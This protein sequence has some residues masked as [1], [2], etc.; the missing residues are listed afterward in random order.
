MK[1]IYLCAIA[2]SVGSLS[3]GQ[4]AIQTAQPFK[5]KADVIKSATL[6]PQEKGVLI[7][8]DDFTTASNW[9]TTGGSPA[10]WTIGQ[11]AIGTGGFPLADLLSTSGAPFALWDSDNHGAGLQD[12][13]ITM[14]NPV[15]TLGY[16][17][18]S[19]SFENYFRPYNTTAVYVE[20]S[21]D[22]TTFP[23]QFQVHAAVP[24][25]G[26]T[27][28]PETTTV[29]ISAAA[30][31][32][33]QVWIRFRYTG[34][35][36]YGWAI[37]DVRIEESENNDLTVSN[38]YYG[39]DFVP[40]S[41]IPAAQVQPIDFAMQATNVGAVAQ[42]NTV[43][44]ADIN[45]GLSTH[46]SA[47]TTIA[48]GATDSLFTTTQFTP[49]TSPLNTP[50]TATL[51]VASDS[52][53]ATPG[54][55]GFIFPPFEVSQYIYAQ[56]DHSATPGAAGGND[57]NQSPPSEEFE[58]GNLY[59]VF[60]NQTAYAIDVV[61]GT[62]TAVGE[63]IEVK[64][65]DLTSGSFVLVAGAISNPVVIAAGDIGTTMSLQFQAPAALTA[66]STYFAAVH[67]YGGSGAGSEFLYGVSGSSPGNT[68]PGGTTSYIFYP[69]MDAPATGQNYFTT[70][71]PMVRLNFSPPSSVSE[72]NETG[73]FSVF[74]NPSN[75]N[76]T[77]TLDGNTENVALS[78]KNIVGQTI[79]NKTVNVSGQTTETISLTDYS[80]GVYFLTVGEE[81]VKLIVE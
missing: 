27:A 68:S 73:T 30:G 52:T 50:Y 20:V 59:D 47:A 41:R 77:I 35:W 17:Q 66:G 75:G 24:A 57:N 74:P 11:S 64:L 1:K 8:S 42:P 76:F 63:A 29:N 60:V 39:T 81:T 15:S 43:L 6:A 2:L 33:A 26:A 48:P 67:A 31:N 9:V 80:K 45:G 25:N 40:Y 21:T 34:D 55:N 36:D 49:P 61:I 56:D 72:A 54:N 12:A 16:N 23:N 53:D 46:T 69:T 65:Y 32:Q 7:W 28:N 62:G 19:L 18:V 70:Q 79:I 58:A 78:V 44:T 22:G 38:E 13:S 3:F 10:N 37:D 71:T 5:T 14:A 4:S 51:S